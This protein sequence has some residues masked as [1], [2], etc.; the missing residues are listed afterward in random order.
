MVLMRREMFPEFKL[1]I[2]L[3]SVP[4]PGASPE[5]VEEG[6]C[7]K[8]EEAVRS[9]EGIKRQTAVAQEDVGFLVLELKAG[10]ECA[11]GAQRSP[12]GSRCHTQ[13]S[14]AGGRAGCQGADLSDSGHSCR[15]DRRGNGR[16]RSASG[17]CARWPR[18][19]ATSWCCCRPFRRPTSSVRATYQ[20]DV[21][22][23]ES[24]LRRHGLTLQQVASILRRQN[25]ELP[26]GT[27]RTP[28]QDVLLRGKNKYEVGA[29]DRPASGPGGSRAA[30]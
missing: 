17:V 25:V 22:I 3:V 13:L 8:L 1:D 14:R 30:M 20:I 12:F 6:I 10:T 4:Y 27:M 19:C 24:Q 23:P 29:R 9:V 26:G 15:S 21:E 5:E 28:G 11:E 2:V 7:Q 18:R 16:S